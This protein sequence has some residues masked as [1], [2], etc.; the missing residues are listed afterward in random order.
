MT[1]HT[2][3]A[4]GEIYLRDTPAWVWTAVLSV[5]VTL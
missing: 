4:L 2:E 5:V 3:V 1:F